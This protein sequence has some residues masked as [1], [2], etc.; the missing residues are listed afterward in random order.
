MLISSIVPKVS[1]L[2]APN[3]SFIENLVIQGVKIC[4][5]TWKSY[6]KPGM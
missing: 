2:M 6:Y 5:K 4:S 3:L 1:R